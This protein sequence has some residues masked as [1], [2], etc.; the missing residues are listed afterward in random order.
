MATPKT[1]AL[2]AILFLAL[3]ACSTTPPV[4]TEDKLK[5]WEI[6]QRSCKEKFGAKFE[7]EVI[8]TKFKNTEPKTRY[9]CFIEFRNSKCAKN[10][11]KEKSSIGSWICRSDEKELF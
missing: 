9:F 8:S 6:S 1:G 11:K 3:A 2:N 5:A 10:L 7:A 4:P